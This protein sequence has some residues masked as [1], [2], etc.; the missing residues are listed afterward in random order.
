MGQLDERQII[1]SRIVLQ[2]VLHDF[3][4]IDKILHEASNWESETR[5]A[6]SVVEIKTV[7]LTLV[8]RGLVAACLIHA[9]PPY[10]TAVNPNFETVERY[11]FI[12]TEKGI[13]FLAQKR[14]LAW[15]VLEACGE[16]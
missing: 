9:D 3:E 15:G 7:L 10:I 2:A 13:R 6:W 14:W 16:P 5:W 1:L 11:W 8:A 12:A 4:T